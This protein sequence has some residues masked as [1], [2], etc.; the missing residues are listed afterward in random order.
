MLVGQSKEWD[1]IYNEV[2]RVK[3]KFTLKNFIIRTGICLG[4]TTAAYFLL[5]AAYQIFNFSPATSLE[6][7]LILLLVLLAG[8]IIAFQTVL[9]PMSDKDIDYVAKLLKI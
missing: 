8:L 5:I 7:F 1:A 2:K 3:G 9:F 4:V 6:M